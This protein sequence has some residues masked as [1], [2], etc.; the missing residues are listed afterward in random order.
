MVHKKYS[1]CTAGKDRE[2]APNFLMSSCP[3]TQI[4]VGETYVL[5]G[6]CPTN[7]RHRVEG[8]LGGVFRLHQDLRLLREELHKLIKKG[9][10]IR[11]GLGAAVEHLLDAFFKFVRKL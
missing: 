8:S 5:S 7:F 4:S 2:T 3:R 10:V 11:L 6:G 1:S 9:P